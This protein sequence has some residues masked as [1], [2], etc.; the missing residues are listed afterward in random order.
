MMMLRNRKIKIVI[1]LGIVML[2]IGI[3]LTVFLSQKSQEIGQHAAGS[4]IIA[5]TYSTNFNRDYDAMKAIDPTISIGGGATAWYDAPFL[6]TFLQQSGSRVDFVDFHGYGQEGN[7]PGD[8]TTL[9][10]IAAGY[11]KNINNLRSLIQHIVPARA[12]HI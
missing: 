3:L 6:Q 2:L 11:E 12:S 9:F 4:G 10:Q 1:F 7:V 5:A 8:Y